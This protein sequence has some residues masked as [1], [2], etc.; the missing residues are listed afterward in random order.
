[1]TPEELQQLSDLLSK[2]HQMCWTSGKEYRQIH[3]D[4]GFY[5]L[6]NFG[7][8]AGMVL[9]DIE[10]LTKTNTVKSDS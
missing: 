7:D 5:D 3:P 9:M 8:R 6:L 2:Y 4:L 1:M 10:K